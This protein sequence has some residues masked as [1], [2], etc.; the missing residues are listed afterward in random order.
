MLKVRCFQHVSTYSHRNRSCVN[1]WNSASIGSRPGRRPAASRVTLRFRLLYTSTLWYI[2][3]FK[4]SCSWA[5]IGCRFSRNA[6]VIL[7]LVS[8]WLVTI[9]RNVFYAI[10]SS[11]CLKSVSQLV[12]RS[13]VQLKKH[14]SMISASLV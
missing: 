4:N 11:K 7:A 1:C 5:S 10:A 6:E 14:V 13:G 9:S 12:T 3:N 8:V 2:Q